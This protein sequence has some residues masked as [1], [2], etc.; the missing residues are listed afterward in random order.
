M[1]KDRRIRRIKSAVRTI[2]KQLLLIL[3]AL[4]V[5]SLFLLCM[6][7][8]PGIVI[9]AIYK[10][11][12]SDLGGTVRWATP[13]IMTGLAVSLTF[14]ANIFNMG[15]DGQLYLGSIAAVWLSS[16]LANWPSEVAIPF[17]MAFSMIVGG[18]Y[19]I[20]PAML[21]IRLNCDEVVT[22][23]LLNYV[24]YYFTDF[25]VLGP[26]LGGGSLV[27][28][29]STEYIAES[30]WLPKLTYFGDSNANVSVFIALGFVL[31]IAFLL[32]KTKYGYEIKI[33]GSNMENARYGGISAAKTIML[34]MALSGMLGGATG[35]MEILGVHHRFSYR[36]STDVGM[37][38]V[39]IALLAGNNPFGVVLTGF[40]YGA[41]KNGASIMQRIADVPSSLVD[42]V[43]G[44]IVLIITTNFTMKK[45]LPKM[46]NYRMGKMITSGGLHNDS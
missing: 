40:F 35:A 30:L 25:L 28:A 24:A 45:I 19:A 15:V 44:S 4:V 8:S 46:K 2:C 42:I 12:A 38:G 7:Y 26:M 43:R 9:E 27:A 23:L 11:I 6:D 39:V 22:T 33:C 16:Y 5:C 10:A 3:L 34:V 17:I 36:Y 14:K 20:I 1:N 31:L 41:L 18:L 29:Q 21:K 37:D 13:Y 32:F